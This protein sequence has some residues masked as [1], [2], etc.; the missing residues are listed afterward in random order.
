MSRTTESVV[1]SAA[2]GWLER[3][4]WQNSSGLHIAPDTQEQAMQKVLEQAKV[5]AEIRAVA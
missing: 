3:T 5:L 4:G 2:R 1:E